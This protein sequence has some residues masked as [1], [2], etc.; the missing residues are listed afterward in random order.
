MIYVT[1]RLV[2]AFRTGIYTVGRGWYVDRRVDLVW[3]SWKVVR[4]IVG[5]IFFGAINVGLLYNKFIVDTDWMS[6]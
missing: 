1:A 4:H 6:R 3:F 2:K 5:M